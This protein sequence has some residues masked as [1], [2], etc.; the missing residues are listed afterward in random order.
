[1]YVGSSFL[2]DDN[3]KLMWIQHDLWFKS[4]DTWI[5]EG[6]YVMGSCSFMFRLARKAYMVNTELNSL[7]HT[8]LER[9]SNIEGFDH[10]VLQT[11]HDIVAAYYRWCHRNEEVPALATTENDYRKYLLDAWILYLRY[12]L[13]HLI[14]GNI[15]AAEAIVQAVVFENS[16]EGYEAEDRLVNLLKDRYGTNFAKDKDAYLRLIR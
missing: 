14:F 7:V 4:H 16:K 9:L 13:S 11:S 8:E 15:K 1:M 10:R 6:G 12:E 2:G 5:E 3:E